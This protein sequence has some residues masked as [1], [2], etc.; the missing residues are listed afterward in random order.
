MI[1]LR[2]DHPMDL[3]QDVKIIGKSKI[4]KYQRIKGNRKFKTNQLI[5]MNII[6]SNVKKK[7]KY[8]K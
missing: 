8:R 4:G 3:Q 1:Y 7:R 6:F 5:G 2:T